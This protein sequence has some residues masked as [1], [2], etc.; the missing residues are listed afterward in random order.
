[1]AQA[2]INTQES[3]AE[4]PTIIGWMKPSCGWSNGV[5]AVFQKYG[6][7][8]DD[9]DIIQQRHELYGNGSTDRSRRCSHASL[10]MSMC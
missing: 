1:M 7:A 5:R 4:N 2:E 9:R 8:F 10:L 6:L 3:K